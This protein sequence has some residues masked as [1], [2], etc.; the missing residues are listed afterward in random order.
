MVDDAIDEHDGELASGTERVSM[1]TADD[2]LGG[3]P[4]FVVTPFSIRAH[5]AKVT[6]LVNCLVEDM[7][8]LEELLLD[9]SERD[10]GKRMTAVTEGSVDPCC[11]SDAG[12]CRR[13]LPAITAYR[14][15]VAE[16]ARILRRME[17][18]Q[19]FGNSGGQVNSIAVA[20]PPA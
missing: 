18:Q 2:G 14:D 10:I 16:K 15:E 7:I 5:Q 12:P 4:P 17:M 1:D 13:C 3:R 19:M 8:G 6:A 11:P 20:E 9:L